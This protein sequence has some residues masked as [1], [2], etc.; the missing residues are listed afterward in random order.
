M[1][2]QYKKYLDGTAGQELE[3]FLKEEDVPLT[4]YGKVRL[5]FLFDQASSLSLS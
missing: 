4:D 3:A 2:D 1:Y 5:L